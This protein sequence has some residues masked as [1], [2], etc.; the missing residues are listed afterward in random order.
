MNFA[1]LI[2]KIDHI[3]DA[4]P[5]R[6]GWEDMMKAVDT[7]AKEK[8]TDKFDKKEISTGTQYTRK[9]NT[10]TDGGTDSDVKAAKKKVKE[11][12]LE[13]GV[14]DPE[15]KQRLNSLIDA[16]SDA[17]DPEYMGYDDYEDII[18]QIRAE[19]GDRTANSIAN[20]PGMHFPRPGHSM[21][22][23]D[24]EFKQMRKNMSPN[25]MTK[26]GKLHKQDSD[27]MK[28]DIKSKFEVEE[29]VLD[30]LKK[31]G[32]KVLDKLGHEDDV[33]KDL[34]K[35]AGIPASAQHGK[36]NMARAN[37]DKEIK[38]DDMEEGNEFS[39]ELAK[40]KAAGETDFEVDGKKYQVSED[41]QA[42][43]KLP[44]M[45]HIKKMCKDGKSVAEI[46][47]MHPDCDRTELKQM[48]ADCKKKL[49]EGAKPDFLDMDK[50]GNKTEPM[51]KAVKDKDNKEE[52][53][54]SAAPGQEEWIK[55]NKAKFVKQYGKEKGMKVLYATANKRNKSMSESLA[56]EGCYDQSMELMQQ[57]ESGMNISSNIDT[58]TGSKSLTVT[59]QGDAADELA[60][61]LKLSGMMAP[62]ANSQQAE[63]EIGEEYSNEPHPVTQSTEVQLQQ[64]NDMH[65]I[66]QSYPKVAGGDNPMAM[67]EARKLAE[68]ENRLM[69]ELAGIK[70]SSKK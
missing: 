64:G 68:I 43:G 8:G 4:Q 32:N 46:C 70:V 12:D 41:Q 16:Y 29:G 48:V 37:D 39:G 69:E 44:S 1:K 25:R 58:K 51:S 10:F 23:D 53:D 52:M 65:R 56:L 30:T 9:S 31:V 47:K 14:L 61:I 54:E 26:L 21:G 19:F 2:A 20:G 38:E 36:P 66:K 63:I 33:L 17:T 40:A 13:E 49:Q 57:P 55:A 27:A 35:K 6:E 59:A 18:A 28:R 45:A 5:L 11:D 60:Q 34:Q 24:L 62:A 22:H 67:A 15:K 3:A 7:S 42:T 50:D